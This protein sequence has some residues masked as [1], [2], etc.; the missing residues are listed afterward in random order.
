MNT[1]LL[2]PIILMLLATFLGAIGSIFMKKGAAQFNFRIREQL[3]NSKLIIGVFFFL[4]STIIYLPALR[5]A[6]LSSIYPISS[7]IY[8]WVIILSAPMLGEK[9]N[10]FKIAGVAFII[11]GILLLTAF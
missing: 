9:I 6:K 2:A 10:R 4:S 5:M 8:V 1:A 7:L 3:R 11:A